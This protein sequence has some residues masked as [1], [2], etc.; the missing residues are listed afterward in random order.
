MPINCIVRIMKPV[1][2]FTFFAFLLLYG[3]P[4][5]SACLCPSL[6]A[7][8][9]VKIIKKESDVIFTGTVKTVSK[10][11]GTTYKIILTVQQS[12]KAK[13]IKEYIIYTSGGCSVWFEEGKTYLVYAKINENNQL[14]T[15][16]CW[17]TGIIEY[18]RKDI[19]ILGKP[20]L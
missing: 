3:T 2:L 6:S 8:K 7:K 18:S 12:W 5:I 9:R 19:K 4:N 1:I 14:I 11:S 13:G 10:E 15:E 17:G 16:M 20:I